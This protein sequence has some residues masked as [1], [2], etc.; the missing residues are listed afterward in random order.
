MKNR[1]SVKV[2]ATVNWLKRHIDQ[3]GL[4]KDLRNLGLVLMGMGI[5]G[6]IITADSTSFPEGIFL[7]IWGLVTWLLGLFKRNRE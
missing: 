1:V 7:L 6:F 5:A 3:E 2:R 4:R